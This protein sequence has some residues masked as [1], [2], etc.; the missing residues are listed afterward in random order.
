MSVGATSSDISEFQ[1]GIYVAC[2]Y[3]DRWYIGT[4]VRCSTENNNVK[5]RFLKRD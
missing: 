2:L 5:V 3:D 1:P 4:I